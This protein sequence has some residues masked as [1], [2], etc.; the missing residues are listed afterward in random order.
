VDEVADDRHL[1]VAAFRFGFDALDL[2]VA[3]STRAIQVR[4]CG[5]SRLPVR[6]DRRRRNL[7]LRCRTASVQGIGLTPRVE[8]AIGRISAATRA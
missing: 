2:V 5:G 3:P 4:W 1:H 8:A 7:P 6:G